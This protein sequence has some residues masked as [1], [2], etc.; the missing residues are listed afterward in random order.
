MKFAPHML[1]THPKDR[2]NDDNHHQLISLLLTPCSPLCLPLFVH[3]FL[4]LPLYIVLFCEFQ[5]CFY[6]NHLN[7]HV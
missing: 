2:D 4:D 6:R 5:V 1:E 7:L 3:L